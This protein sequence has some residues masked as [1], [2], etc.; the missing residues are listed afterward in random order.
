[1][2]PILFSTREVQ[3]TLGG[4]MTVVWRVIKPQPII[5]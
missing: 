2:K 3:A 5:L 1:M 4:R